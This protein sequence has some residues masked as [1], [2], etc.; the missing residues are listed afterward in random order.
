MNQSK[1]DQ[2]SSRAFIPLPGKKKL[3]EEVSERLATRHFSRQTIQ[4]YI[5]WIKH[6]IIYNEKRHPLELGE[7]EIERFLSHL[8]LDLR[9]SASTQNQALCALIALYRDC[10]GRELENVQAVRA[11]QPKNTPIVFSQEEIS[12]LR[13][14]ISVKYLLPFDLTYG[15]GL[16]V[17]EVCTLRVKDIDLSRDAVVI[18][19]GKGQ[20]DRQIPLPSSIKNNL[21]AHLELLKRAFEEDQGR[22]VFVPPP[23]GALIRKYPKIE[24]SFHWTFLFP[25][26]RIITDP[27]QMKRYRWHVSTSTFQRA[28]ADAM[29]KANIGK[30]AS[31][32]NLRHSF[33][34]H[35][36][37]SGTDIRTVQQLL[38]HSDLRTTMIY[39][40]VDPAKDFSSP[41]DGLI[42]NTNPDIRPECESPVR[43][44]PE[45]RLIDLLYSRLKA[46]IKSK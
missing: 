6:F 40:Q 38:G 12:L 24:F 2:R 9:V 29:R 39:T 35:L 46:L 26:H 20:R 11:K 4:S 34:T 14:T 32:H 43:V 45:R 15:C 36:L 23:P 21:T 28:F 19:R 44:E 7:R 37:K 16:R 5:R 1:K 42:E 3:L 17:E 41:L 27:I 8:A 22:K 25:S 31:C 10:L 18:H 33:A 13:R 30:H